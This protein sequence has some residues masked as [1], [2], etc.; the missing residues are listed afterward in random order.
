MVEDWVPDLG[1]LSTHIICGAIQRWQRHRK[2]ARS[3]EAYYV[4]HTQYGAR[5]GGSGGNFRVLSE[6]DKV[7]KQIVRQGDGPW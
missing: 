2:Q 3:G 5:L 6:L 1:A 7:D 4:R